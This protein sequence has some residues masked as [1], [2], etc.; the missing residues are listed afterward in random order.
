[1]LGASLVAFFGMLAGNRLPRL[2]H[3]VFNA[4]SFSLAN[5][6]RFYLLVGA[7]D[8]QFDRVRL[9]RWLRSWH[10]LSVEDV[11]P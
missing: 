6:N 5:G 7:D 8:P 9:G 4:R 3:P 1:V 10:A 11:G 2:Y